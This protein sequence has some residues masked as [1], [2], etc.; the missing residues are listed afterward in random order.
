[1]AS[2]ARVPLAPRGERRAAGCEDRRVFR[3]DRIA[4]TIAHSRRSR[5]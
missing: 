2:P 3:C 5:P 4:S 1:M